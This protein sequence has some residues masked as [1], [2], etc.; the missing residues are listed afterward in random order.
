MKENFAKRLKFLRDSMKINSRSYLW[1]I[2]RFC[3]IQV[4]CKMF[5]WKFARRMNQTENSSIVEIK[6]G[7]WRLKRTQEAGGD[8]CHSIILKV[9]EQLISTEFERILQGQKLLTIV[10][11]TS[12]FLSSNIFS[13]HTILCSSLYCA[14]LQIFSSFFSWA[15]LAY[16]LLYRSI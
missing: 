10:Q 9:S 11:S 6:T 5:L 16:N 15:Y 4:F 1:N 14:M 3:P 13:S 2:S 8:G 12:L 7:F